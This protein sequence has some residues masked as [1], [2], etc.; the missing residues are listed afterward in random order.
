[1]EITRCYPNGTYET[2]QLHGSDALC[3]LCT[4]SNFKRPWL[5]GQDESD[6]DPGT[7]GKPWLWVFQRCLNERL[8]YTVSELRSFEVDGGAATT[9]CIDINTIAALC[10]DNV[11]IN[12]FER[13]RRQRSN[14]FKNLNN[15]YQ[16]RKL[17]ANLPQ[18][19]SCDA[20]NITDAF[21]LLRGY[22]YSPGCVFYNVKND[23]NED[24]ECIS[25]HRNDRTEFYICSFCM[26]AP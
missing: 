23:W 26:E 7:V 21:T 9:R 15:G 5:G 2:L 19:C 14:A 17:R 6:A 20:H 4:T 10:T 25:A 12:T 24:P 13:S 11:Q 22:S 1:M 18:W 3:A 16:E 8:G